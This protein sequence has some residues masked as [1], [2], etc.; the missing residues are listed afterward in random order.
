MLYAV[1]W[2]FIVVIS[3]ALGFFGIHSILWFVRSMIDRMRARMA[4]MACEL[5]SDRF[6][7]G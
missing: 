7:R 2:Y 5:R 6:G 3:G 1:W 4:L